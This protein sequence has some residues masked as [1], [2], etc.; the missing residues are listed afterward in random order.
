MAWCLVKYRI[1]VE[2][3]LLSYVQEQ[4]YFYLYYVNI[5][6]EHHPFKHPKFRAMQETNSV[7][8]KLMV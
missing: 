7:I 8:F 2:G 5:T 4:L 3:M 1:R 6:R